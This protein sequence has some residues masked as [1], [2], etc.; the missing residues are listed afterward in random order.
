[1]N[2]EIERGAELSVKH[3]VER[4]PSSGLRKP[5]W[6]FPARE[7]TAAASLSES[8]F[9]LRVPGGRR[10]L[11]DSGVGK[12]GGLRFGERTFPSERRTIAEVRGAMPSLRVSG[13]HRPRRP[14]KSRAIPRAGILP[15]PPEND[16][17]RRRV[18]TS[19]VFRERE[20]PPRVSG[21]G[22]HP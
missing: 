19:L 8:A 14:E 2:R 13:G 22:G 11:R 10:S 4:L 7:R 21:I 6:S 15:A 5:E 17:A 3:S 18:G 1:M 16:I 12:D 9:S 20:R